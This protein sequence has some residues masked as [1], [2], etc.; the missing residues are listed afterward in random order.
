M[1]EIVVY[2]RDGGVAEIHVRGT[3]VEARVVELD[4]SDESFLATYTTDTYTLTTVPTT[5]AEA[6]S[7]LHSEE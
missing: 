1:E 2:V 7:L 5:T 3:P 6:F 4:H